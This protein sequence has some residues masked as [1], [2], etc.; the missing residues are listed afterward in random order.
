MTSAH[1]PPLSS[2]IEALSHPSSVCVRE[3][4][5]GEWSTENVLQ[6]LFSTKTCSNKMS[7]NQ[8]L[9]RNSCLGHCKNLGLGF[10]I[11]FSTLIDVFITSFS[12][13]RWGIQLQSIA[14][15][16]FGFQFQLNMCSIF[17]MHFFLCSTQIILSN[18][19][20]SILYI[21]RKE[22]DLGKSLLCHLIL[23]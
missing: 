16:C 17:N 7:Y 23:Y 13:R 20:N 3:E 15:K 4:M 5:I 1:W 8:I 9:G 18:V 6:L 10:P 21:F 11:T 12:I 14:Y 19:S 22:P 2:F